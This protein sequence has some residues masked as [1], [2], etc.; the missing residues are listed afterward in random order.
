MV[1]HTNNDIGHF[2]L[3]EDTDIELQI[4]NIFPSNQSSTR[5]S[6]FSTDTK[7]AAS[8]PS[9]STGISA[10]AAIIDPTLMDTVNHMSKSSFIS[11]KNTTGENRRAKAKGQ[12]SRTQLINNR[13]SRFVLENANLNDERAGKAKNT[14]GMFT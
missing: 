4:A 12:W 2:E 6:N 10:L 1:S 7:K 3:S 8:V 13:L 5:R 14:S 9:N 11:G